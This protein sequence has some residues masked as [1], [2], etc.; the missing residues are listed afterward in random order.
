MALTGGEQIAAQQVE[1]RD[2]EVMV[3]LASAPSAAAL[4]SGR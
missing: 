3:T 2:G 4:V 1:I